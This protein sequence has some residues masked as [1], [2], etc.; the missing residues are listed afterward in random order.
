MTTPHS[1]RPGQRGSGA[2]QEAGPP[3]PE[4]AAPSGPEGPG[5][6]PGGAGSPGTG[7]IGPDLGPDLARTAWPAFMAAGLACLAVGLLLLFWPKATLTIAAVLIGA[8]L[9]VAGLLRLID[10]FA[11]HDATGGK[12]TANVVIGVLAIIVGLFC[13]RHH[14]VTI[15]VLA[16]VVGIFWVMHGIAD[17]AAGLFVGPF[18]GRGLTVVAGVFSLAAGIL[19]LFWPTISIVILVRVIG[20]WLIVYGILMALMALRLRRGSS[21]LGSGTLAAA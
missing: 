2:A 19:V 3:V 11:A 6:A 8:S 18:P 9:I 1:T 13:L 17:I 14:D 4:Q 5:A 21:A 7:R 10:G 20:I 15:A 12:R 16:I